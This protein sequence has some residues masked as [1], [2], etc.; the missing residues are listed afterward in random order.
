[1]TAPR[2]TALEGSLK[3]MIEVFHFYATK[4]GDPHS[5]NKGEFHALVSTE[6][7]NVLADQSDR[8]KV[9][10]LLSSLDADK[11]GEVDFEEYMSMLSSLAIKC[12][13]LLTG[14]PVHRH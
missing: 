7:A 1:M 14:A 6:L 13:Q 2:S 11:N 8:D 4:Q 3:T 9:N 10:T 12:N 5:L